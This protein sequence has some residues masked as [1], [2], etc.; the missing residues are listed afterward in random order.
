[1]H[2]KFLMVCLFPGITREKEGTSG[3]ERFFTLQKNKEI[4]VDSM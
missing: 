2:L 3:W 4:C 1:M